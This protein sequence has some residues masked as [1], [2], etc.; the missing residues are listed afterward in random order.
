VTERAVLQL[1]PD[2]LTVVEVAP[3]IDLERDI[4]ARSDFPL[5]V[6]EQLKTMDARLFTPKRIGLTLSP[7]PPHDRIAALTDST[8]THQ[9]ST[10][11]VLTSQS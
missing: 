6:S 1:R 10:A 9:G 7:T 11:T 8:G 3:G 5:Q 2:G 4:L